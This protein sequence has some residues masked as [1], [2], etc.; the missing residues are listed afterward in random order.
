MGFSAL[1]AMWCGGC[2]RESD[3]EAPP[4]EAVVAAPS[5]EVPP[6][7]AAPVPSEPPPRGFAIVRAGAPL[8]SAPQDAAAIG[9]LPAAA[10]IAPGDPALVPAPTSGFVFTVVGTKDEFVAIESLVDASQHCAPVLARWSDLRVA[11]FAHESDLVDV[12]TKRVEHAFADGTRVVLAPGVA[13]GD[14]PT[15]AGERVVDGGDIGLELPLPTDA[16]GKYYEPVARP[17]ET[18]N[19]R[20]SGALA[21]GQGRPLGPA[22][23]LLHD[24]EGTLVFER[25]PDADG[26]A[27][28]RVATR[29]AGVWALADAGTV[30]EAGTR[31]LGL[32]AM[33]SATSPGVLSMLAAAES[34]RT[35][36]RAG[37]PLWW[38]DGRAAGL[39]ERTVDTPTRPRAVGERACIVVPLQGSQ[40]TGPELCLATT[41]MKTIEPE[42]AVAYGGLMGG[43]VGEAEEFGMIGLLGESGSGAGGVLGSAPS[44]GLGL[45]SIGTSKKKS[46]SKV[47]SGTAKVHGSLEADEIRRPVKAVIAKVRACY[48]KELAADPS[49]AGRIVVS[50]VIDSDGTVRSAS[51][52]DSTM[53]SAKVESC[54]VK[55]VKA[56]R[57]P[58]PVGGGVVAVTYPFV[59]ASS[60]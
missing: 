7:V 35:E 47:K 8:F 5:A 42:P 31:A 46:A 23:A 11:L 57:F 3:A 22:S 56:L 53:G 60:G 34:V 40:T 6:T 37:A 54:I 16:I 25:K 4:A 38:P 2:D 52:K 9:S 27:L 41:D 14:T 45:G 43:A 21:Y 58:A 26:R 10:A 39:V 49:L 12:T 33:K 1:V 19:D 32:Y 44:G 30:A 24:E 51:V 18:A 55:V 36:L 17:S 15:G 48:E 59:F 20:A 29:C 13:I 50:W 28:V